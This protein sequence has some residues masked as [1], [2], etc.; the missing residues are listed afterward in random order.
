MITAK[1]G[2]L[3]DDR[4]QSVAEIVDDIASNGEVRPL[5]ARELAL[6]EQSEADFR[7]GRT[8]TAAEARAR[9]DAFLAERRAL[10]S[11]T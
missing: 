4:L 8:L 11:K 10:R 6:L 9:T 5:T 2:A 7:E 1:L 3:D